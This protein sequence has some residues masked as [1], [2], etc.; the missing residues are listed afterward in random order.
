MVTSNT[1]F[2]SLWYDST[3]YWTPVSQAI[4]KLFNHSANGWNIIVS[5]FKHE[6]WEGCESLYFRKGV[7]PFIFG[8]NGITAVL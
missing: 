5:K 7:N 6:S 4:G 1:I 3:W 8:L 2:L